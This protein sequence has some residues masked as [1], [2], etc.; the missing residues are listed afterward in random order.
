MTSDSVELER[1]T[2]RLHGISPQDGERVAHMVAEGLA[3]EPGLRH[4]SGV[5]AQV[6]AEGGPKEVARSI[7][8][9]LRRLLEGQR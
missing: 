3:E 2:L 6:I 9:E 8:V 1:L 5:K 4:G 7:V